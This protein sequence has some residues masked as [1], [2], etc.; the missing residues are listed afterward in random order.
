MWRASPDHGW[1]WVLGMESVN[2]ADSTQPA[3]RASWI[4]GSLKDSGCS[5]TAMEPPG[6]GSWDGAHGLEI[7]LGVS[8]RQCHL[9]PA[10]TVCVESAGAAAPT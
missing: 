8:H 9:G 2:Q 3:E 5:R 10:Y 6:V 1:L 7:D 4:P